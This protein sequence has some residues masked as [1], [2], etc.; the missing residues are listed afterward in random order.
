MA[1]KQL[2]VA[3]S[4]ASDAITKVVGTNT[5]VGTTTPMD[6]SLGGTYGTN[7]PGAAGNL[8]LDVYNDGSTR[9]GLGVSGGTVEYQGGAHAYY[10]AGTLVFQVAATGPFSYIAGIGQPL[11]VVAGVPNVVSSDMYIPAA[12]SCIRT[13]YIEVASGVTLD[14]GAGAY[15]DIT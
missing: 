14:V 1:R 7:T 10:N 5:S 4:G 12:Y 9:W 11:A 8:K 6:V 2:G 3:P 13:D 15:L